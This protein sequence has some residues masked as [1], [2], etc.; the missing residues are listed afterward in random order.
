M[1]RNHF[2]P[3]VFDLVVKDFGAWLRI[4]EPCCRHGVWLISRRLWQ[5]GVLTVLSGLG[6]EGAPIADELERILARHVTFDKVR[7]G[8]DAKD[9]RG[10]IADTAEG[11]EAK[12]GAVR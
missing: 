3:E 1:I 12:V 2:N 4:S 8:G 7:I 9:L 5:P 10:R 11:G 6:D